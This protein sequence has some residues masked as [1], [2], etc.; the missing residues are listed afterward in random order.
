MMNNGN[1]SVH[2]IQEELNIR[3]DNRSIVTSVVADKKSGSPKSEVFSDSSSFTHNREEIFQEGEKCFSTPTINSSSPQ[4]PGKEEVTD[5]DIFENDDF[6]NDLMGKIL[7]ERIKVI[8][9]V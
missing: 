1:K 2:N 3:K 7:N 8:V 4:T 9:I 6:V 5:A